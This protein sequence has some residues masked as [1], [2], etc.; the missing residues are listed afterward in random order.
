MKSDSPTLAEALRIRNIANGLPPDGGESEE[1]FC[2]RLG[3]LSLRLPNPPA[4]RRAV[5]FHDTNH[6][7]TDYDNVFSRGEMDI[8]GFEIASGC[9]PYL[10]AWLIN[11]NMFALGLV[12]RPRALFRAF[13]R[14]RR[15]AAS[16]YRRA[17][18]RAVLSAITVDE[19]RESLRI[20]SPGPASS[21]DWLLFASWGLAAVVTLLLPFGVVLL[22]GRYFLTP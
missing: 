8:A 20:D 10:F 21:R 1:T 16:M 5:F 6:V 12:V 9:G 15:S 18:S 13:V 19:L 3:R 14:G 11:L 7:L 4:R 22:I 2:I 17:E